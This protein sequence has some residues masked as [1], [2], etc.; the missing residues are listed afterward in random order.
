VGIGEN[1]KNL[2]ADG[3]T[4]MFRFSF[5]EC[6]YCFLLN[7]KKFQPFL[8]FALIIFR[9]FEQ[10]IFS[11]SS[12]SLYALIQPCLAHGPVGFGLIPI[13]Q[14]LLLLA[15]SFCALLV[16]YSSSSKASA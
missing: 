5:G 9:R 8:K 14:D 15:A 4:Y 1:E 10:D 12:L 6:M 3:A 16:M 7:E 2:R 11:F 13:P